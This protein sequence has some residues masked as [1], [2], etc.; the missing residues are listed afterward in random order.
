MSKQ[1]TAIEEFVGD[2]GLSHNDWKRA[3]REGVLLGQ[4][5]T[6]CGHRSGAPKAACARCG[7]RELEA[8]ELPTSGDVYTE[9]TVMVPPEQFEGPHRV[10]LIDLGSARIMAALEGDVE[11]GETVELV[12]V[13]EQDTE[14]GPLFG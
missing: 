4:E 6:E 1:S 2:D 11:I 10:A 3:L 5:C 14:P 13:I 8:V 9:T 12:G 7:N